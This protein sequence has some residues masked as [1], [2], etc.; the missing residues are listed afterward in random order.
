LRDFPIVDTHVHLYDTRRLSYR[1]MK[2]APALDRPHLPK[3]YVRATAGVDVQ[4]ILVVEVD[5]ARG[6]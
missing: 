5:A 4:G 2:Q 6:G 1:W 3:V